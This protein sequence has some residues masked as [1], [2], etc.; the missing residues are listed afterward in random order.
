[1]KKIIIIGG[2]I[3]G[4]TS[5]IF[6][7]KAGFESV[8]LEKNAIP[9]GECTGWDRDGCHIDGCIHWLTG[10]KK[11]T[12][13]YDLWCEV[14]A[15]EN[16]D[17]I[18]L[19]YFYAYDFDG[20][21]I[22]FYNDYDKLRKE[23]VSVSPDDEKIIDE[24]I[25]ACK[26]I[27]SIEMPVSKPMDM[28]GM[29]EMLKLGKKMMSGGIVMQKYS[30]ITCKEFAER[31]K[32]PVLQ[33]IFKSQL[34]ENYS[35][36]QMMFS[37]ATVAEG[38]GGIPVGG[39]RAMSFRMVDKYK[40]LGGNLRLNTAVD[41][42]IID[43][44]KAIGVRLANGKI[45][46][47]DY[48]ISACDADVTLNKLLGGKYIETRL[49]LCYDDLENNPIQSNVLV[50]FSVEGDVSNIPY[51]FVF[52]AEPYTVAEKTEDIVGIRVYSFDETLVKNGKTTLTS[53][54]SQTPEQ[55]DYWKRLYEDK[56]AYKAEKQR[57]ADELMRRI[58]ERYPELEGRI[59]PID[60][61]TPIT[62][63]RYCGAYKGSWMA[64]MS[65]PNG[66][67]VQN[68][69]GRIDGI[70]NFQLSGQWIYS[71]GGLP[72]ALATGKFAVQRICRDEKMNY[73]L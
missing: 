57:I 17:I 14:G 3:S 5:G 34:P 51:S 46:E 20:R 44:G 54:V 65:T 38:N 18:N 23:L 63:E 16:T 40:S 71:P 7:Q 28:M 62:Y 56:A 60:V 55:F 47:G 2:G 49:K 70:S 22:Y 6:A 24:F 58:V 21:V 66:S 72:C 50:A 12:E 9:G 53:F 10:T 35:V 43:G 31:F 13:L 33:K 26:S 37:Y 61:V 59:K 8:V 69:D 68:H 48:V 1:M 52:D 30:K 41:E 27:R 15:L 73:N 32:S 19:D 39:S 64:F 42:I 4:I 45:V 11:N 67:G 29:I 25:S 36:S